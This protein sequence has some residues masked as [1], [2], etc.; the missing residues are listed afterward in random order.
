MNTDIIGPG[1]A[2]LGAIPKY[3]LYIFEKLV[4]KL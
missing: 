2:E 1:S 3:S 4:V